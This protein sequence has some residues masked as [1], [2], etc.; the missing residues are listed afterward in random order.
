MK[1]SIP[2]HSTKT[3][4]EQWP[5]VPNIMK[6]GPGHRFRPLAAYQDTAADPTQRDSYRFFHHDVDET[7]VPGPA[8]INACRFCLAALNDGGSDIP[9]E[10]RRG[11]WRHL[12]RHLEDA[13]IEAPPLRETGGELEERRIDLEDV[14]LEVREEEG[15]PL[16]LVGYAAVFG[17]LSLPMGFGREKVKR[18]AFLESIRDDDVRALWNHDSNIVL[19]RMKAGTLKLSEDR[20]GLKTEITPPSNFE[21]AET[22]KRGDVTGMSIRFTAQEQ[23]FEN[24]DSSDPDDT[25][26]TILKAKLTEVSPVTFPAFPDTKIAVRCLA[27]LREADIAEEE[28]ERYYEERKRR[29]K[30]IEIA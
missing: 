10:S 14:H 25:I 16:K 17:K 7:G 22:I 18:G 6:Q 30:L 28:W 9:E 29:L 4:A 5:T 1:P 11:A 8:N 12:A 26:R 20:K 13:E 23:K 2:S 24:L 3:T 27:Q 19:G 21:F 15:E